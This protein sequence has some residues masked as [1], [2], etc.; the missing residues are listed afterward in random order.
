MNMLA[1]KSRLAKKVV[2]IT[3]CSSG[4]IGHAL[5]LEFA[6]HGCIVY[7]SARDK[8]KLDSCLSACNIEGIEL[9]VT[10]ENSIQSAVSKIV[11]YT[12]RIDVLVNNAGQGCVGPAVEVESDK[13]QQVMDVNFSGPARMCRAVAPYMMDRRQGTIVNVG[14]VGGYAATPWVGYYAASKAALH[15]LS[16]SMRV[17][18]DP[19]NVRVVV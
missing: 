14:S 3:G 15:A 8:S 5:A 4:S 7:A 13:V 10:N 9:D 18:L 2:L 17:E 12:G 16:D 19:F 6:S 1:S 11:A